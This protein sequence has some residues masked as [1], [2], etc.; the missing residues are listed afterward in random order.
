MRIYSFYE[1]EQQKN[2]DFGG[3]Q[4]S[5]RSIA[6]WCLKECYTSVS[7]VIIY[8]R[9]CDSCRLARG[10]L[11]V[12]QIVDVCV[13]CNLFRRVWNRTAGGYGVGNPIKNRSTLRVFLLYFTVENREWQ[14]MEWVDLLHLPVWRSLM[15][16][17]MRVT[18]LLWYQRTTCEHGKCMWGKNICLK[19]EYLIKI[20]LKT[21]I[22]SE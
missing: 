9:I 2:I 12:T 22:L 4:K 7:E 10:K 13:I 21:V 17:Y 20:A 6:P 15:C 3:L 19:R 5:I 8:T 11:V 18:R 1:C 14:L 16:L